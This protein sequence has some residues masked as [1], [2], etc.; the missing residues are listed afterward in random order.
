MDRR[1]TAAAVAVMAAGIVC[2]AAQEMPPYLSEPVPVVE[3]FIR[4]ENPRKIPSGL[5]DGPA[6]RPCTVL[7]P[8]PLIFRVFMAFPLW[9]AGCVF[10]NGLS[11]LYTKAAYT[12]MFPILRSFVLYLLLRFAAWVFLAALAGMV[13]YAAVKMGFPRAKP[14]RHDFRL[15]MCATGLL[16]LADGSFLFF[17]RR[18]IPWRVWLLTATGVVTVVC[19]RSVWREYR[20]QCRER[21]RRGHSAVLTREEIEQIART[22]ADSVC[23]RRYGSTY[24]QYN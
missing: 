20:K 21:R 12:G 8:F 15:L 17:L 11:V 3:T 18:E 1:L 19:V 9:C 7:T 23:P 16:A 14:D 13:W 22:L 2:T 10:L 6:P 4:F 24:A 5:S